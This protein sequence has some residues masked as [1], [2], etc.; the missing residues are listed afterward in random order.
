[1]YYY[2]LYIFY[3]VKFGVKYTRKC[4]CIHVTREHRFLHP[5]KSVCVILEVISLLND[6]IKSSYDKKGL[7]LLRIKKI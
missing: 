3:A 2:Y 5:L 1:M 4:L 6:A 7:L